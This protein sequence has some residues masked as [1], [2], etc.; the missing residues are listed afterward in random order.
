M[1]VNDGNLPFED[2][3]V[4]FDDIR[5]V[6]ILENKLYNVAGFVLAQTM[7]AACP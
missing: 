7:D 3:F 4:Q 5:L 2:L 1:A 6:A